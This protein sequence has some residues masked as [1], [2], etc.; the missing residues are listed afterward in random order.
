MEHLVFVADEQVTKYL[1][2]SFNYTGYTDIQTMLWATTDLD[3][4][5]T[6]VSR[7]V[8]TDNQL[9]KSVVNNQYRY[10]KSENIPD[11]MNR[12]YSY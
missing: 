3:H 1:I 8:C 10:C 2:Y 7:A 9:I 11:N 6:A 12:Q 5:G 4:Q